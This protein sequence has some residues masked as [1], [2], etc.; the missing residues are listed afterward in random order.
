[1]QQLFVVV[2]SKK[3]ALIELIVSISYPFIQKVIVYFTI[4]GH[5]SLKK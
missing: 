3:I 5:L 4:K 1:M 2:V